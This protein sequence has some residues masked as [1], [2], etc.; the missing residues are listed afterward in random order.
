MITKSI[1]P[2]SQKK[3]SDNVISEAIMRYVS[4]PRFVRKSKLKQ[5]RI[6]EKFLEDKINQMLN[7]IKTGEG[8]LEKIST[9]VI[10]LR[11]ECDDLLLQLREYF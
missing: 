4:S 9:R 1:K 7:V 5:V 2:E 8:E 11:K 10:E 6:T 3:I